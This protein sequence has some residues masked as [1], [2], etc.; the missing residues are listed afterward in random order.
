MMGTR[1]THD[2]EDAQDLYFVVGVGD[3]RRGRRDPSRLTRSQKYLRENKRLTDQLTVKVLR[4]LEQAT[5]RNIAYYSL[6]LLLV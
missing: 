4:F 5:L 6:I 1:Y 2:V 3:E